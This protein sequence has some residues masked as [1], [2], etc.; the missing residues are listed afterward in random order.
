MIACDRWSVVGKLI[1]HVAH[2]SLQ[3]LQLG[4]N[5]QHR[6]VEFLLH[7]GHVVL[8]LQHQV[9]VWEVDWQSASHVCSCSGYGIHL[10]S[11]LVIVAGNAV[12]LFSI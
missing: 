12:L 6:I 5:S 8:Y 10:N 4:V 2:F 11:A 1:V 9:F 7:W 3:L